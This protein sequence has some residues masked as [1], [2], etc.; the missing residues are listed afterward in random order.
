MAL[1]EPLW[2]FLEPD[3][4][5]RDGPIAQEVDLHPLHVGLVQVM[6]ERVVLGNPWG[7]IYD[8]ALHLAVERDPLRLIDF[9]PG[10]LQHQQLIHLGLR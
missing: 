5:Q 6:P 10:L 3:L 4:L 7:I 8:E 1:I 2:A 9:L